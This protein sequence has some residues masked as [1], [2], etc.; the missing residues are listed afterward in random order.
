MTAP[1]TNIAATIT[2]MNASDRCDRCRARA[3][4]LAV[5]NSGGE[6]LFCAHH[7]QLHRTALERIARPDR[8]PAPCHGNSGLI[9]GQE[10]VAHILVTEAHVGAGERLAQRLRDLG[11]RVSTCHDR[12]GSCRVLRQAGRCPIDA[13]SDPVDL[14]VHVRGASEELTASEYGLMCA[15][16]AMRNVVIVCAD[17]A[18]PAVVPVGLRGR[19]TATAEEQLIEACRQG[20]YTPAVAGTGRVGQPPYTALPGPPPLF[21]DRGFSGAG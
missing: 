15:V 19:A 12:V 17:P 11:V 6:L 10:P 20:R 5:L 4:V 7:A 3:Q 8:K 13:S 18:S 21:S 9:A 1:S 2:L 14:V 16:Q